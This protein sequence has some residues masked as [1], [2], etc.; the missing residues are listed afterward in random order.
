M[1]GKLKSQKQLDLFAKP[2]HKLLNPKHPLYILSELMPWEVFE[3]EFKK[4]YSHTG[5]PAKPTRLMVVLLESSIANY[6]LL[7]RQL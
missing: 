1:K 2:L 6:H 5:R 4:L 7:L 3:K